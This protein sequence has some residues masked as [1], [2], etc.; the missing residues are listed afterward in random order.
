MAFSSSLNPNVVKTA[1]DDVFYQ[2]WD[3]Q[4]HP[5][6]A[7]A[8]SG[9]IFMQ[10]STDRQAEI[11]ETFK[12]VS[13]WEERAEEEDVASDDPRITNTKTH[14]VTNFAKSVDIPKNFFDDNLHGAYEKM[15]RDMARKGRLTRD[16]NAMALYRN[17]FTTTLTADGVSLINDAHPLI[18]G[19]TEDN[20][21]TDALSESS[22]YDAVVKLAE[23]KDQA[24]VVSGNVARTLLVPPALF[25]LACE[26]LDSEFRS[27]TANNDLNVYVAKYGIYIQTSNRLGAAVGGSDTAWWLLADNFGIYRWVRQGIVTDLVPYQFQR[28]NNYIYKGEFREVVSAQ[29]YVGI[30]GSDGTT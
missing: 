5:G 2:E 16:D 13:L 6:Y 26:I 14:T 23:Q 29:D 15:V 18:G 10:D 7:D 30:V 24:G 27:D 3:Y 19:G 25:K 17:S 28:N 4:A 22:V 20:K 21:L 12:G 1:L 11:L 8:T 9:L